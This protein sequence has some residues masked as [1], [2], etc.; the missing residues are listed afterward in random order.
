MTTRY[1]GHKIFIFK[2]LCQKLDFAPKIWYDMSV[3][4]EGTFFTD[5]PK[6][7]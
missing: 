5:L 4:F 1:C 7:D 2:I 3:P 6:R